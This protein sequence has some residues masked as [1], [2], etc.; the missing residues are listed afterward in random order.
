ME[1]LASHGY[2]VAGFNHFFDLPSV[3]LP[4]GRVVTP[5]S[6]LRQTGGAESVEEAR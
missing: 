3:V 1:D 4:D 2:V 6:P 5:S